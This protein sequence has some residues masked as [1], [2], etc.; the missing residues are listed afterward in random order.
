MSV[1]AETTVAV[2]PGEKIGRERAAAITH[3]GIW[4]YLVLGVGFI[5]VVV[6]HHLAVY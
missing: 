1:P 6:T 3:A 2:P 5:I 4:P